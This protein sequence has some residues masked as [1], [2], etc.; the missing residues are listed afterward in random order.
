MPEGG[1]MDRRRMSYFLALLGI[2]IL[3]AIL[4]FAQGTARRRAKAKKKKPCHIRDVGRHF[5]LGY[6]GAE[7]AGKDR[8]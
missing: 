7:S 1:Q 2:L 4:L 3:L 8:P 6:T 5:P